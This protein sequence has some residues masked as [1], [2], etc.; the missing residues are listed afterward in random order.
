MYDGVGA[1]LALALAL[2]PGALYVWAYERQAGG[3]TIRF[4][5]RVLRFVG[6]SALFHALLAPLTYWVWSELWPRAR[7]GDPLPWTAWLLALAYVLVP[8]V[9]GAYVGARVQRGASWTALLTGPQPAPRAWDYLFHHRS[10]GWI[11]LRL[12]SGEWIGGAFADANGRRSYAASYPEPPDLYLAA[13]VRVDPETGEFVVND[14]GDI[15]LLSGGLLV[16]WEEVEYLEFT[17]V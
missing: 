4:S 6:G 10:D 13:G 2:V 14:D 5:D 16:S 8:I 3:K 12:K 1:L 15:E 7:D 11:R 9:T 17:D